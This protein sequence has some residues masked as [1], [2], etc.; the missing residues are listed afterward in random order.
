M[1]AAAIH[2]DTT[3][4]QLLDKHYLQQACNNMNYRHKMA[5]YAG[6]ASVDLHS[7]LFFR[8]RRVDEDAYVLAVKKN[9]LQVLIPRY[10][11]EST[12][13]LND[14]EYL[15]HEQVHLT[16]RCIL[17]LSLLSINIISSN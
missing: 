7:Q 5:Q 4:P 12:L 3:Y 8:N 17:S 9:A 16:R 13:Y 14:V 6:R 10:G 1:L 15:Y 2:A 11:L